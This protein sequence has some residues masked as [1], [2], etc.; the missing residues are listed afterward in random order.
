MVWGRYSFFGLVV[1]SVIFIADRAN[2][3][4][5]VDIWDLAERGRVELTPFLDLVLVWNRGV[6]YGLF[7]QG[8]DTG[9]YLLFAFAIVVSIA[10]VIWLARADGRGMALGLG[11]VIGGAISNASD[12]LIYGAVADFYSLHAM[13]FYW[14]VFNLADVAI[15]AGV[16]ALLYVSFG[17]DHKSA[18][19]GA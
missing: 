4:W 6:S 13:G 17:S 3:I 15:V 18:E 5:L 19:N 7:A 14:Y 8:T 2:K 9:R 10:L 16:A 12:R 1:A 11:L